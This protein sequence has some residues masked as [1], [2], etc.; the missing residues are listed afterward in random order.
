MFIA[1]L[2]LRRSFRVVKK[3]VDVVVGAIEMMMPSLS[4]G[5]LL[6]YKDC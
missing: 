3:R 5:I 4:A 1:S 2:L 6:V